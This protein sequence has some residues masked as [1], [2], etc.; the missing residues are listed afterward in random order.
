MRR[1]TVL[2]LTT[3]LL[4]GCSTLD[5]DPT[6]TANSPTS[7]GRSPT[8][9][10]R[11]QT[12]TEQSPTATERPPTATER[13]ATATDETSTAEPDRTVIGEE[14][15][16]FLPEPSKSLTVEQ[17]ESR[18][19]TR[20][21]TELADGKTYCP[22]DSGPV[23]VSVAQRVVSLPTGTVEVTLHN[24]AD[25]TFEW[26]PY[27]WRLFVR[28][29]GGWHRLAPLVTL[30]PVQ[31]LDPGESYTYQLTVDNTTVDG[32]DHFDQKKNIEVSGLGPGAYGF[33]TGGEMAD[34]GEEFALAALFGVA[35]DEPAI[36][37]TRDVEQVVRRDATLVVKARDRGREPSD[38]VVA[39][40]DATPDYT[41]FPE[42]VR[43][44]TALVN[45]LSYAATDGIDEIRYRTS[46]AEANEAKN[47][48]EFVPPEG[49][50]GVYGFRD[51]AFDFRT[52]NST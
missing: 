24:E 25:E 32:G 10:E 6:S 3:A 4:S 44:S 41:F 21:C 26:N 17:V 51:Y 47:R 12:A 36:R 30:T 15:Y 37:P 20:D 11:S 45:T 35:G 46:L 28:G 22:G 13:S 9:T 5:D 8:A 34:T 31:S 1:R 23:S 50:A 48:L 18:L 14:G 40:T 7:R 2:A 49:T 19:A 43:Q 16:E 39:F 42:E 38:V 27:D 29:D 52:E 33:V